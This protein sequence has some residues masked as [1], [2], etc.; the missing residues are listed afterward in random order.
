LIH[1]QWLQS[2]NFTDYSFL[3]GIHNFTQE[4]ISLVEKCDP[5]I[6]FQKEVGNGILSSDSSR[7]FFCGIIDILS[8]YDLK[9]ATEVQ[10]RTIQYGSKAV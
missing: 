8:E 9:K 2:N 10:L 6:L 3:L 4:N 7:M 1:F 5:K